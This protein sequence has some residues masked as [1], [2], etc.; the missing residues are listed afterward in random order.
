MTTPQDDMAKL[1]E[2]LSRWAKQLRRERP[3]TV[4]GD[5]TH[6]HKNAA[7]LEAAATAI[8]SITEE[9]DR[10]LAE[11]IVHKHDNTALTAR[12]GELEAK[13]KDAWDAGYT[14]GHDDGYALGVRT[15]QD[16]AARDAA[17]EGI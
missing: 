11:C 3:R 10:L 6:L 1:V 12:V 8:R 16:A 15:E 9:R 17:G 7:E 13:I 14:M 2:Q 4:W 5:K